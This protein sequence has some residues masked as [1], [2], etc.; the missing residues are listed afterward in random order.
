MAKPR[1]RYH[2][3]ESGKVWLVDCGRGAFATA[4]SATAEGEAG[5]RAG[6]LCELVVDGVAEGVSL[7]EA[8][9]LG[10]G[11][12]A[13]GRVVRGA[14]V[15]EVLPADERVTES[16]GAARD[17]AGAGELAIALGAGVGVALRTG[18]V[19][20]STGLSESVGP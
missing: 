17:G 1:P 5:G 12:G 9:A 3:H 4:L 13:T 14:G 8:V 10:K 11:S 15:G 20:R 19:G 18:V 16:E 2:G 6:L 7:G